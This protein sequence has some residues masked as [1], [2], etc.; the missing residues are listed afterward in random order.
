MPQMK[1]DPPYTLKNAQEQSV[2]SETLESRFYHSLY[3]LWRRRNVLIFTTLFSLI[4]AFIVNSVQKPVYR[5]STEV[6]LEPKSSEVSS[7]AGGTPT[8]ISFSQDPTFLL[9]QVRLIKG[10]VLAERVLKNFGTPESARSLLDCFAIPSSS[11]SEKGN[12][13]FSEAEQRRLI[14]IIRASISVSQVQTGARIISLAVQGY[15]PAMVKRVADVVAQTYIELNYESRIDAFKQTFSVISKSLDEIRAKIKIGE[16][17]LQK[18]DSEVQLCEALKIYGERHPNVINLR[19][20]IPSLAEQLNQGTQNLETMEIGQRKDLLP[21][22]VKPHLDLQTLE[23]IEADLKILKPILDQE[24]KTNREM[25]NSIF[26]KLQEVELAG[27]K[28]T[29]VDASVIEPAVIPGKPVRPDKKMNFLVGLLLGLFLGIAFAYFLEYLDSSLRN[30]DDVRNYLKIFP[31][32]MVPFVEQEEPDE[33]SDKD[34]KA[35]RTPEEWKAIKHGLIPSRDFWNTTN[36]AIPMYVLEAYRIIRT[37]LAFGAGETSLKVLQFTSAVKGEGKSTSVV[38]LGISLAEAGLRTLIVDGDMRKPSI[39]HILELGKLPEG[40]STALNG[41]KPWQELVVSTK[42]NNLF[43]ITVGTIP[44]NPAELLSSKRLKE[45]I[46]EFKEHYDMVLIDSPPVVS[47]ADAPIIASNV[48][49]TVLVARA[50]FIPR[51]LCLQAK[52]TLESVGGK[53]VGCIL[54][55]VMSHHQPYYYHPYYY[56]TRYYQ[57][58]YG[59]YYGYGYGSEHHGKKKKKKKKRK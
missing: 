31:L 57:Y 19:E 36:T 48:E 58:G 41:E 55:S 51:H 32:G 11:K 21:L 53:I 29:W 3:I 34:K 50:G 13:V 59:G 1:A 7:Q 54:N 56:G 18:V 35:E 42:I 6:V 9:T 49:G 17:A 30:L 22:L 15:S 46:E 16:I 38:N 37:N 52:H 5:A 20:L 14:G 25:Y 47:V 44:K 28:N 4:T 24:V 40:F 45:L 10:P 43:C 27:G 8:Q 23:P 39:H 2:S 26:K 33:E 12:A